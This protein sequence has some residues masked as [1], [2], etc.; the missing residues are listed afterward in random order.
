MSDQPARDRGSVLPIALLIATVL[1][2]VVAATAT[3]ATAALTSTGAIKDRNQQQVAMEG[4]ARIALEQIRYGTSQCTVE[5]SVILQ[6]ELN[7][8]PT[9]ATCTRQQS[10]VNQWRHPAVVITGTSSDRL[11]V[12]EDNSV[13]SGDVYFA[14]SPTSLNKILIV[15]DGDVWKGQAS[16]ATFS[17]TAITRLTIEDPTTRSYQCA[18]NNWQSIFAAPVLPAAPAAA[19]PSFLINSNQCRVFSPG[20][21]TNT[22]PFPSLD[23]SVD[24]YL[25]S[26]LYYFENIG[27][28]KIKNSTVVGGR[29]ADSPLDEPNERFWLPGCAG[30][31]EN[32]LVND[33]GTGVTVVLGGNTN[34]RLEDKGYLELFSPSENGYSLVAYTTATNG[35]LGVTGTEARLD[36]SRSATGVRVHGRI[37]APSSQVLLGPP[38]EAAR[39]VGN[40]AP[41]G[42]SLLAGIVVQ[43][44]DL[45][46][47]PAAGCYNIEVDQ[48]E[49]HFLVLLVVT[50]GNRTLRAVADARP[51]WYEIAVTSWWLE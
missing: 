43:R 48:V 29:P 36:Q 34:I 32:P 30:A 2:V 17:P 41:C 7:G 46:K 42:G 9:T 19:A 10:F 25:K 5:P 18:S 26:G 35:Y 44:L 16:C 39:T 20:K 40:E 49:P 23:G 37:W 1:A 12:E 11:R 38:A 24:V 27:Q 45:V 3:Y 21:Y 51:A 31:A 6:I 47:K 8:H 15:E 50:S 28:V 22:N 13:I 33:T 14:A 4:A